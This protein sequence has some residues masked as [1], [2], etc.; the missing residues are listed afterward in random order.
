M[1]RTHSE[2]QD[3][4]TWA[5]MLLPVVWGAVLAAQ[6]Y[7]GNLLTWMDALEAAMAT[8]FRLK[9]TPNTLRFVAIFVG[10]YGFCVLYHYA[11]RRNLRSGEEHGS[12]KWGDVN[13]IRKKYE[14]TKDPFS[15]RLFTQHMRQGMNQR[16]TRRNLNTV[17]VGGSGSGKSLF[18]AK[19]NLMQCN[20][21]YVILDP[22]G[23]LLEDTGMLLEREG[24]T[25]R[26]LDL[27]HIERSHGY[28]PFAYFRCE[29][30]I[31]RLVT[32]L[33]K[34][35]TPKGSRTTDSFWVSAEIALLEAL[36]FYLYYEAPIE[37][38]TFAMVCDMIA[39]ADIREEDADHQGPLDILFDRLA[40]RA[41]E[42]IAVKQYNI[43]KI[44]AGKTAKS[45]LVSLGVR[46]EKF[47]IQSLASLTQTDELHLVEMGKKKV[48]LFAIIPDNDTSFNFIVGILYTQ[49]FQ[50][51]A[52]LADA[53]PGR[54]LT[55]HVHFLMDEF[56]NVALPNDFDKVVATIRSREMSVSIVLQDLG[57]IQKLFEK[58]WRSIVGNC[59]TLLYLG[60]NDKDTHKYISEL[61]G[62]ETISTL[63]SG[64]TRGRSGSYSVNW[65][66]TGRDLM[67]PEEVRLMDNDYAIFFM[68]G[69]RGLM[70]RKYNTFA[71]PR[72]KE[73]AL[74]GKKP[75]SHGNAPNAFD[76]S[77]APLLVS[78]DSDFVVLDELQT[79]ELFYGQT[80]NNLPK[81]QG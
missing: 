11:T 49:L 18:Y 7:T 22:K 19:P 47:N 25:V 21:S 63:S 3:W 24:Y 48:A 54:K 10:A 16:Q 30:D 72:L 27:I 14:E 51:L 73:T 46:L 52:R 37:E 80:E 36:M 57:Q 41:P 58:E 60:G 56:A 71:H 66:Q 76:Y 32:N 28:N 77:S 8:P 74:G 17:V 43:F 78:S 1:N 68:R 2:K 31:M 15:N 62:K 9:W 34:N 64:R 75:Y 50:E 65:Q 61:L 33:I 79:Y 53:S 35:T 55:Q 29:E 44:A 70:D 4:I 6:T 26:V 39:A 23:E 20:S 69:E 5:L 40:T 59:D 13:S 81:Q 67:T 42:H 12:A 38:Q 45:I